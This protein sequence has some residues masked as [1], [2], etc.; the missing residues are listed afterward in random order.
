MS[1]SASRG[2]STLVREAFAS[3][4]IFIV[5][6]VIFL[7]G[8]ILHKNFLTVQNVMNIVWGVSILGLAASGMTFVTYSGHMADLTLPAII[9]A[10]GNIAI[11]NLQLGLAPALLLGLATGLAIG[12]LNGL[13]VGYLRA[14]PILWTL[15]V[16]IFMNGLQRLLWGNTQH[17]PGMRSGTAGQV[18]VRLFGTS[19]LGIPISVIIMIALFLAFQIIMKRSH[20][21]MQIKMIGSSYDAAK[22][23]GIA[24]KKITMLCFVISSLTTAIA[25]IF[26]SSMAGIGAFYL[27][28]GYDFRALTA[29]VIGGVML[30]GGRG[31]MIGVLGGVLTIG[32]ILNLLSFIG[33]KF[34]QQN[35]VSGLIFILVV[36]LNSI[37]QRRRGRASE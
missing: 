19:V 5:A 12:V 23:S 21:G 29:I 15:A 33:L 28:D 31:N 35:I 18:F 32:V 26:M 22:Y 6:I 37:Q 4:G 30:T 7:I 36:W 24:V 16:N 9:S 2:R 34:Y 14:N 25:G 17:Y 13:V 11:T 10:S 20:F 8:S 3:S 1:L 27:G